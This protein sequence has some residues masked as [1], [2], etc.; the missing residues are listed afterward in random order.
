[1]LAPGSELQ[2]SRTSSFLK[3]E[4][5]K[6]D[7]LQSVFVAVSQPRAATEG[8]QHSIGLEASPDEVA[9][10]SLKGFSIG[11]GGAATEAFFNRGQEQPVRIDL[12]R[13]AVED[14]VREV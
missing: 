1:M 7:Q 8:S 14:L 13:H 2:A 5:E 4:A 10:Q 11:N 3:P 12:G 9:I 6:A